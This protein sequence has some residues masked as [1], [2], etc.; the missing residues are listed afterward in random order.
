MDHYFFVHILCFGLPRPAL[1]EEQ[2]EGKIINVNKKY[3]IAFTDMSSPHL[4]VGD[5]IEVYQNGQVA[6]HLEVSETSSAISKLISPK[7]TKKFPMRVKFQDLQIGNRVVKMRTIKEKKKAARMSSDDESMFDG[8]TPETDSSGHGLISVQ[9]RQQAFDQF[10]RLSENYL[11]LTNNLAELLN[12]KR[13]LDEKYA[14][15]R[16]QNILTKATV[17]ELE[18]HNALLT[19]E[20]QKYAEQQ[21]NDTNKQEIKKLQKI[22]VNL[23]EKLKRM[24]QLLERKKKPHEQK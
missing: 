23:K 22:I 3:K 2:I 7:Q 4:K 10:Q 8:I 19:Q 15:L 14:R 5:I 6:T 21:K 12:E 13:I 20:N 24:V 1:S 16:E 17:T 9:N 18:S 11:V